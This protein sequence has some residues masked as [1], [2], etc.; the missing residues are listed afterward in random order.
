[1]A[2][3]DWKLEDDYKTVTLTLRTV[4]STVLK[5]DVAGVEEI[6]KNL[7]DFRAHMPPEIP[8]AFSLGQKVESVMDPNWVTEPEAMVG[9]SLLHLR[10]PRFGWLH[11][12]IPREEARKLAEI[13]Q[14]QVDA[15]FPGPPRGMAN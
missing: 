10:D 13:L 9:N 15:P 5:F 11:Y 8:K 14:S 4:P 6:L 3:A 2:G 7:G 1:M 12:T